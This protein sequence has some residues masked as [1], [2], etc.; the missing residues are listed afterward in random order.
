MFAVIYKGRIKED[1]EALY[2]QYW[3]EVATYFIKER[4]A[5]GSRLHKTH[6]GSWVA[7]SC[8]PSKSLRDAA[9]PSNGNIH[10]DIPENIKT[11]IQGIKA[12]IHDQEEDICMDV[13]EDLLTITNPLKNKKLL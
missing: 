1:K 11:A 12:C 3:K 9:W 8:W 7:Y 5:L 6:D 4:G 2:K 10:S 13:V